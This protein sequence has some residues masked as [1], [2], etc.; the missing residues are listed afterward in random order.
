MPTIIESSSRPLSSVGSDETEIA[1][2]RQKDQSQHQQQTETSEQK[3]HNKNPGEN[4]KPSDSKTLSKKQAQ[5]EVANN[6]QV[7]KDS[8]IEYNPIN[9]DSMM[10]NL[11]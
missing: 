8:T 4:Q 1:P 11:I 6:V 5:V 3:L 2:R 7:A 10:K 9:V